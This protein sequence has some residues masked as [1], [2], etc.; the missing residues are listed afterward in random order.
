MATTDMV[1]WLEQD[2]KM[3]PFAAHLLVSLQAK[4][5]VITVA[6]SMGLKIP[7]KYLPAR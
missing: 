1:R 2:Y 6:G 4:Y 5:D 7:K 3:E